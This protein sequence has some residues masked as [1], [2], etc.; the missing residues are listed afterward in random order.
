MLSVISALTMP[1]KRSSTIWALH[2]SLIDQFVF[3]NALTAT[4]G[5]AHLNELNMEVPLQDLLPWVLSLFLLSVALPWLFLLGHQLVLL[6][7]VW[8]TLGLGLLQFHHL[9]LGPK[10]TLKL[11]G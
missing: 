8:S 1:L 11:L 2:A 4:L 3:V 6:R 5:K 9:L 10:K 7:L